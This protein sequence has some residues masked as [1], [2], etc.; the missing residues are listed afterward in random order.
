MKQLI[1]KLEPGKQL[2]DS[3]RRCQD[4]TALDIQ[5][6]FVQIHNFLYTTIIKKNSEFITTY[7][8]KEIHINVLVIL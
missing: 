1:N 7:Q 3:Y 4:I 6:H 8:F 5:K 2:I